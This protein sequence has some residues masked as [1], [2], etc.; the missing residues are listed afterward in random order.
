MR[1]FFIISFIII[2]FASP[3]LS[4]NKVFTDLSEQKNITSVY[5]SKTMMQ[6]MPKAMGKVG[7][8]NISG[9]IAKLEYIM[10]LNSDNSTAI[11]KMQQELKAINS[12]HGYEM[13]MKAKESGETTTVFQK[14]HPKGKNEFV[15][16]SSE[17]NELSVVIIVGNITE[18][19][20]KQKKSAK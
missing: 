9:I 11:S 10:I 6:M 3:L 15:L 18:N 8:I 14:K 16:I 17:G 13:L 20:I 4:Q 12:S 19:D 1:K 5:I 7:G 2:G